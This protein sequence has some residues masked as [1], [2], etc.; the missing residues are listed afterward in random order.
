M[1][2][3]VQK[4]YSQL[5]FRIMQQSK[6]FVLG[7]MIMTQNPVRSILADAVHMSDNDE[8]AQGR[9]HRAFQL[10]SEIENDYD[11]VLHG[12]LPGDSFAEKLQSAV[13][14]GLITEQQSQRL[15]EYDERRY[16]CLLT[17]AFDAKLNDID[18]RPVRP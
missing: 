7:D 15:A 16:D 13:A 1:Y 14:A 2:L 10:L 5:R 11:A 12:K 3:T 6:L 9:I 4:R 8:D 17:D 18:V